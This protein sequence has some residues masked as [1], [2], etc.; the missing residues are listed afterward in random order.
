MEH[1]NA[2][3]IWKFN[4]RR[5]YSDD[6]LKPIQPY[7]DSGRV[8]ISNWLEADPFSLLETGHIVASV[9][10]GGSNCYHEAVA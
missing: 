5:D 10:H 6:F 3:V 7:I 4:K 2:Q 8:R 1:S 9:H